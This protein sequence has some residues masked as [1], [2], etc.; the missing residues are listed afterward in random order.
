M[1]DE[2]DWKE[3]AESAI[4]GERSADKD[5]MERLQE[6]ELER[7]RGELILQKDLNLDAMQRLQEKDELI[8]ELRQGPRWLDQV[9]AR[10]MARLLLPTSCPQEAEHWAGLSY[11]W[12]EE[13]IAEGKRRAGK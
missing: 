2:K 13:L 8:A 9:A 3:I 4:N 11:K 10:L 7:L 12:A 1:D 6:K 5:A